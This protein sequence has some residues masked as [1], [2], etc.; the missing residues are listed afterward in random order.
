MIVGYDI[1]CYSYGSGPC[2]SPTK[3]Y[4]KTEA[5]EPA[6]REAAMRELMREQLARHP[7]FP[8]AT[9]I[10]VTFLWNDERL[11]LR[12]GLYDRNMPKKAPYSYQAE[13]MAEFVAN[14]WVGESEPLTGVTGDI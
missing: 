7:I 8:R 4:L 3:G 9:S 1:A 6:D 2:V 13:A 14:V 5:F 10:I 11:Q 12:A